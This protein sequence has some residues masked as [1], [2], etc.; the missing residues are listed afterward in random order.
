M[1]FHAFTVAL[2]VAAFGWAKRKLTAPVVVIEQYFADSPPGWDIFGAN[3][4]RL[5]IRN[6]LHTFFLVP[7]QV[8]GDFIAVVL[9]GGFRHAVEQEQG[10][11]F[12]R[13]VVGLVDFPMTVELIIM[14]GI[15][16]AAVRAAHSLAHRGP[17]LRFQHV[18]QPQPLA[19]L[20]T[21]R[22]ANAH[23]AQRHP[24]LIHQIVQRVIGLAAF[25]KPGP[26]IGGFPVIERVDVPGVAARR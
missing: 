4:R 9:G 12:P 24:G 22:F 13:Q 10:V 7:A 19:L 21:K 15:D 17:A 18:I 2:I 8:D 14:P 5:G 1:F 23:I 25:G 20:G 11:A 3:V 16:P 6:I 26:D